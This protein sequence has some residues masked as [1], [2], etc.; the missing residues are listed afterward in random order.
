MRVGWGTLSH[1]E[2]VGGFSAFALWCVIFPEPPTFSMLVL[3]PQGFSVSAL[4]G[5]EGRRDASALTSGTVLSSGSICRG[6][7]SKAAWGAGGG[8]PR[9]AP[10]DLEDIASGLPGCTG[11][12][13]WAVLKS[14]S[15]NNVE[16]VADKKVHPPAD[17]SKTNVVHLNTVASSLSRLV[18]EAE[19]GVH[20]LKWEDLL[21]RVDLDFLQPLMKYGE[22]QRQLK[23]NPCADCQLKGQHLPLAI[24]QIKLEEEAV[25]LS[26]SLDARSLDLYPDLLARQRF[27][28]RFG[29]LDA[30]GIPTLKGRVAC[31]V[32]SGDELTLAEFIFQNGLDGLS[33][34]EVAAVLSAFV[35]C[36]REQAEVPAPT[37]G[38]QEA[39]SLAEALHTQL[40]VAQKQEGLRVADEDW[41]KLCNF[42][43]ALVAYE[44]ARGA[45]FASVVRLTSLHEGS[46]LGQAMTLTGD[47]TLVAKL[48]GASQRIRRD[49]VF[50]TSLY[51][52]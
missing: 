4:R 13:E 18:E 7:S 48:Q 19:G 29:F 11:S 42:D 12:S 45:S 39:R 52:Q 22:L 50:A 24:K 6:V 2:G 46:V 47:L 3:F 15:L 41:W 26:E 8:G 40:L 25:A 30:E 51:L 32:V 16:Q 23:E 21:P 38:V 20:G 36:D 17:F 31:Q 27:L 1:A 28:R 34:E 10:L 49:I 33:V 5:G 37:P 35:G 9:G 44:W 14:V 43:M